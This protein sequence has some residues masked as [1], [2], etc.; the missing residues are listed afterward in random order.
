MKT[1][2]VLAL[3]SLCLAAMSQ[4]ASAT[5]FSMSGQWSNT[6]NPNGA[7]S[8]NQG[9]T[10]LP[11]VQNWDAAGTAFAGCKQHAWAPSN[12]EGNFLPSLMKA[13]RCTAVDLGPDPN[14]GKA[15]ALAGDIVV[16]TVDQF[17]GNPGLGVA[18]IEFTLPSGQDGH[19]VIH[20][21][22]WDADLFYGT[23]RPQDWVL[24][25]NGVVQASGVLSGAVSRSQAQKFHVLA[26]LVAGDTVDLQLIE[27]PNAFAGFFVGA[28]MTITLK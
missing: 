12:N 8:Y 15:N 18:N 13:N 7:W 24:L 2:T 20:G 27:D 4:S 5:N 3:V 6:T 22:V 16:H 26:N 21:F 10:P 17:N 25:V 23:S 28:R 14:N 11:L 1:I 9:T 19:Y